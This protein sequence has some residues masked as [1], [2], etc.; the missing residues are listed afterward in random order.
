MRLQLRDPGSAPARR[1]RA[2]D[3]ITLVVAVSYGAAAL[4]V[5]A[6]LF[7]RLVR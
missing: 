3:I 7:I 1:W 5:A 6:G 2:A 4:V